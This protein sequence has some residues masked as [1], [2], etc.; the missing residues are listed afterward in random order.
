MKKCDYDNPH[1]TF[2]KWYHPHAKPVKK[3]K[4][5]YLCPVCKLMFKKTSTKNFVKEK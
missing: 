3:E 1:N 5:W 4:G 2:E